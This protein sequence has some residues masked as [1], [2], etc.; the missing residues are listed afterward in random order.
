MFVSDHILGLG[1][2]ATRSLLRSTDVHTAVLKHETSKE[3]YQG[4]VPQ[5]LQSVCDLLWRL[6]KDE[7][8]FACSGDNR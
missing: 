3:S 2:N 1:I 5:R 4:N 6:P 7:V 8:P